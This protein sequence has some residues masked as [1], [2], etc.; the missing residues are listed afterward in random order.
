MSPLKIY[1]DEDAMDGD[2][3]AALRF[4]GVES[5]TALDTGLI[6]RSDEDQLAVA[7]ERAS[8][9]SIDSTRDGPIYT[10]SMR[11]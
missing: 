5:V 9:I 8:A 7:T 10:E 11:V 3:V 4:R 6:G 2:L 1:F